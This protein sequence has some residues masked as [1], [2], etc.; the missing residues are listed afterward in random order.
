MLANRDVLYPMFATHNAQTL[1]SVLEMAGGDLDFE[2]QRLHGMGEE[3]YAEVVGPDKLK[4]NC[5]VYAPV[6]SHED[7]LPY[8][9][10]RLLENG[11]NTSFVNRIIDEK[12]PVESIVADPVAEVA[13]LSV[14]P[15][16]R[17]PLPRDIYG[18]WRPHSRGV[19][20]ADPSKRATLSGEMDEAFDR[21]WV[22]APIVG[23][24]V[25]TGKE[26]P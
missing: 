1:S 21:G 15:H 3:L 9:V 7:L 5:R 19:S 10:R 2:F 14:K 6:G 8:L 23:G 4:V 17:I 12:V 11:A 13:G 24:K 20:L 25:L 18:P 22:A 16:P 26:K